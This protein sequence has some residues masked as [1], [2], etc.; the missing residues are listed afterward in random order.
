MKDRSDYIPEDKSKKIA[1]LKILSTG[2]ILA[3]VIS[4]PAV[5]VALI[6][7]YVL[8]LSIMITGVTSVIVLFIV[9]GL[10]YKISKFVNKAK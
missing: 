8:R 4:V 7:H 9:M 2:T 6:M 10:G 5:S 3:L 1:T